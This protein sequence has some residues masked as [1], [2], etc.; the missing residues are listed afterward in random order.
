VLQ[1]LEIGQGRANDCD[2]LVDDWNIY[3]ANPWTVKQIFNPETGHRLGESQLLNHFPNHYELTRKDLMVK[4][5]K[6]FRREMEKE[7]NPIAEKDERGDFM[8]MDIVPMTYILPGDY[9]IFVEEFRRKPDEMW[10][11]KPTARAQGKGI[12]LVNKLN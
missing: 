12:F 11:M 7:G 1:C 4:N 9:T 5:I 2:F 8:H 6:R 10:I 3:W